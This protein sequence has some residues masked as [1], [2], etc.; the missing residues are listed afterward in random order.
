MKLKQG[1]NDKCGYWNKCKLV[2][3]AWFSQAAVLGNGLYSQ[4]KVNWISF[5]Y[6]C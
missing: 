3:T 6:N 1:Q 5:G 4:M 2:P